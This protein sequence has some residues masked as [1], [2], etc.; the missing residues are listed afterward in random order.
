[1]G[2][3]R[4]IRYQILINGTPYEDVVPIRGLRQGDPISPHLFVICTEM[5]VQLLKRTELEGRLTGLKVARGSPPIS[6]LLFADDSIF[7]CRQ[8]DDE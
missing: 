6:H 8:T 2:C 1:M 7:Y 4:S 5:L 3:V